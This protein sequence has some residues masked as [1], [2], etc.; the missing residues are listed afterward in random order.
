MELVIGKVIL[1]F[2][3][4]MADSAEVASMLGFVAI[5]FGLV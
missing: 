1:E 3:L 4:P 2:L 5:H